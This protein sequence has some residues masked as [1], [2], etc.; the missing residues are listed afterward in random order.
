MY[1]W[2]L[3][4]VAPTISPSSSVSEKIIDTTFMM[5][6]LITGDPDPE[7]VKRYFNA[8]RRAQLD[9][10][11]NHNLYTHHY[12][13]EFPGR[14]S[15]IKWTTKR[16][17]PG[18][19]IVFEPYSRGVYEQSYEWIADHHIFP[20]GEM[21][22][23]AYD[24]AVVLASARNAEKLRELRAPRGPAVAARRAALCSCHRC[25]VLRWY[26]R[27]IDLPPSPAI[28]NRTPKRRF[29]CS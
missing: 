22:S 3:C 8:L 1:L 10:D 23:C 26:T 24:K 18:E 9:L 12:K 21:G 25:A 27:K 14:A 16:W 7:D 6:T 15:R 19:R 29:S 4:L 5:A 28:S 2:P 13:K 11:V 17:G 20:D